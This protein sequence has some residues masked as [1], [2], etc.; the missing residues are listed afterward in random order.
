MVDY[1]R[2][3]IMRMDNLMYGVIG[4]YISFYYEHFWT[5][6]R[7]KFFITGIVLVLIWKVFSYVYPNIDSFYYANI[8]YPLFCMAVLCLLP[9]LS[10]Y[11]LKKY[12]MIATAITYISLISYSLYLIHFSLIK[13]LLIDNIFS[14]FFEGNTIQAI[15][16]KNTFYWT[17]SILGALLLYKYFEIPTMKLRD[18]IKFK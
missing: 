9:L 11:S 8:F 4:A 6:N 12:G 17:A 5:K 16:L 3:V 10:Q 13:K 15:L 14:S 18:K 1:R 2:V 7:Y